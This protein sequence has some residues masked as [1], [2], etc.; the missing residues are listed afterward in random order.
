VLKVSFITGL[1]LRGYYEKGCFLIL[2]FAGLVIK[3]PRVS[4]M[5]TIREAIGFVVL[6]FMF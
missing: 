1:I 3:K 5:F 6:L 4:R 2:S